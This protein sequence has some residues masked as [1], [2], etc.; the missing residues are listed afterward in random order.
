MKGTFTIN[1]YTKPYVTK[2]FSEITSLYRV[3]KLNDI[4]WKASK[5]VSIFSRSIKYASIFSYKYQTCI[6]IFM[7]VSNVYRFC[8]IPL[9]IR[10]CPIPDYSL[11]VHI[12][13]IDSVSFPSLR[14]LVRCIISSS[15]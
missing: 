9:H 3:C 2:L 1:K 12:D 13:S 10:Y 8:S 5:D 7:E 11:R 4:F 14:T 15:R 6:D